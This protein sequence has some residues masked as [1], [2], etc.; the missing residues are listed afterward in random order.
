MEDAID[1]ALQSR[2]FRRRFNLLWEDSETY[3]EFKNWKHEE[4]LGYFNDD[5]FPWIYLAEL[6]WLYSSGT[7]H[8]NVWFYSPSLGWFWTNR[9]TYRH[10]PNLTA[11]NQ[12]FIYR[13]SSGANGAQNGSW[14]LITVLNSETGAAQYHL[15]N[16]G[17][18]SL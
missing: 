17:Y 9:E 1:D 3:D 4:W 6:G 7:S 8:N 16:Y 13:V 5:A 12:R 2:S 14:S 11:D 10:H 18:S 15:Y